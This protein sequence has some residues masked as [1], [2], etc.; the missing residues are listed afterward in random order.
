MNMQ[1]FTARPSTQDQMVGYLREC[2]V[3]KNLLISSNFSI[4][5]FLKFI[6][7]AI[8]SFHQQSLSQIFVG[9]CCIV[10][11]SFPNDFSLTTAQLIRVS[12]MFESC[13]QSTVKSE[14]LTLLLEKLHRFQRILARSELML[15]DS[16]SRSAS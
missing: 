12:N 2:L 9:T 6:A 5:I 1:E 16:S 4:C 15:I 13:Y 3:F 8:E 7:T 10:T 14:I 11:Q